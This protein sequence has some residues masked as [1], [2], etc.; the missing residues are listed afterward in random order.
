MLLLVAGVVG[1]I[2]QAIAG[3]SRGGCIVSIA[4]GFIGALVGIWLAQSLGLPEMFVINIGGTGFPVVWSIIGSTLFLAVIGF[5]GRGRRSR[6][7][8]SS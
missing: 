2:G 1:A 4:L 7:S 5:L 3:Y 6:L 8:D